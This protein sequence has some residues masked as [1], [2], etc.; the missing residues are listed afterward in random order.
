MPQADDPSATQNPE[1]TKE[2]ADTE[3]VNMETV[4]D[5][6]RGQRERTRPW[7]SRRLEAVK[8]W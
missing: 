8:T 3:A 6:E 1:T 4:R 5:R 2:N 7:T